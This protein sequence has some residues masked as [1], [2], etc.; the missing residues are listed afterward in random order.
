MIFNYPT[1]VILFSPDPE[2]LRK[3]V[4]SVLKAGTK[5]I[6]LVD[7][8]DGNPFDV[9]VLGESLAR[10]VKHIWNGKNIGIASALN[11]GCSVFYEKGYKW[12]LTLDQDSIV[13][14]NIFEV[15]QSYL[16][17]KGEDV[18]ILSCNHLIDKEKGYVNT[19]EYRE[20]CITSGC[21]M[22]L[23]AWYKVG[24]FDDK[25]FIDGVDH[26]I[27]IKFRLNGYKLV[28]FPYL[29]LNHKLGD[30][31]TISIFGHKINVRLGHSPMRMFYMTRNWNYLDNKY[32]NELNGKTGLNL[33]YAKMILLIL[34]LEKKKLAFL[35]SFY[36]GYRDY[37]KGLFR[38][39]SEMTQSNKLLRAI[40]NG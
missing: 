5:E 7:N 16:S 29:H 17:S 1:L 34:L 28:R 4:E 33:S 19:Y 39:F 6:L 24:K 11:V 27:C 9:S 21:L 20:L 38:T 32:N 14:E 36:M 3:N 8:T 22:N 31:Q 18:A 15:Y 10:Q 13:P 25:L 23:D 37:K 2:L 35:M 30:P 12:V 40:Y 26:D